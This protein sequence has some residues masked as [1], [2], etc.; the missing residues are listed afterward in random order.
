LRGFST[1]DLCITSYRFA[2]QGKEAEM[3]KRFLF[4]S[5]KVV[6]RSEP[7]KMG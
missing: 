4:Y 3:K 5:F 1:A 2:R 6:E 7:D